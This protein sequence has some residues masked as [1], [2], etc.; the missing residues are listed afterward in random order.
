MSTLSLLPLVRVSDG[1]Q[2][3]ED[4]QLSIAF[5]LDD[6]VTPVDLGGLSF[7][8]SIGALT[9]LSSSS[10]Q[11][12]S[13]GPLTNLL[14]ITALAAATMSWPTGVYSLSLMASDG[15]YTRDIFALSTL[16]VGAAQVA[17]VSM[18]VAPDNATISI[19]AA[20]P[21]ALSAVFQ[22]LEPATVAAALATLPSSEL[23]ALMQALVSSLATQSGAD[24]PVSSGQAF[25]N[26]SGYM[27]IAQ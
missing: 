15:I 1:V 26:S 10:G 5:Y 24:A 7:T 19:A 16:A 17:R 20:I 14:A 6:G 27:V 21:S 8:L 12:I 11:I 9:T 23:S 18:I 22:A 3:G 13:S 25:V 4:W 2:P